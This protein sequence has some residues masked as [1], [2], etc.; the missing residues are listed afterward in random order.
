MSGTTWSIG[1]G[2]EQMGEIRKR[3]AREEIG[4]GGKC[5]GTNGGGVFMEKIWRDVLGSPRYMSGAHS[6]QQT[7]EIDGLEGEV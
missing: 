7:F 4:K 6:N 3:V 2:Y 5:E 1:K